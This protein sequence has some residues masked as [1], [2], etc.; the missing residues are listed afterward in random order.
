MHLFRAGL[1][2]DRVELG[3]HGDMDMAQ[4][5]ED[6]VTSRTTIN[7]KLV[8]KADHIGVGEIQE[9]GS[10][11]IA[12]QI[13]LRNLKANFRRIGVALRHVVNRNNKAF[14]VGCVVREGSINRIGEGGNSAFSRQVVTNDRNFSSGL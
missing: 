5:G 1:L 11:A 7:T 12:A 3:N 8:L 14:V 4:K 6:M 10:A 13:L 2:Q 9:I